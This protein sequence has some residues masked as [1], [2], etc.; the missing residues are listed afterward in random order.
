MFNPVQPVFNQNRSARPVYGQIL[1]NM[2]IN[3][4][5]GGPLRPQGP[6]SMG[7]KWSNWSLHMRDTMLNPVQPVFNRN[8]SSRPVY[9]Q[10]LPN[11]AKKG[12]FGGPPETPGSIFDGSKVVEL[13]TSYVRY[14]VQPSSTGVQPK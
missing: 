8:R 12:R 7:P 3:G 6:F 13:V 4:L 5:F 14:N 9:G 2:A 11:M 1:P 10:I